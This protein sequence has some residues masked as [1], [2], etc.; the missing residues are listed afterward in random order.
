MPPSLLLADEISHHALGNQ[1]AGHRLGSRA[2]LADHDEQRPSEVDP[3]EK[4]ARRGR[5]DVVQHVE[6][7]V[8]VP[9]FVGPLVPERPEQGVPKGPSP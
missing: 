5:V 6:L 4:G 8:V 2:G 9:V 3:A 1:V 7:G